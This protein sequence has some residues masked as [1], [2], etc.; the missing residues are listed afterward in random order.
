MA[1]ITYQDKVALNQE[2]SIPDIN[3]VKDTDMNQIK[4]V[5]NTNETKILLAVSSTAPAQCSTGDMYFNTTT[6]LIYTAIAT[7]TWGA[8]GTAP[9]STTIYVV[10]STNSTYT[11]DG[12]TLVAIGGKQPLNEYSTSQD[13][14]YSAYYVNNALIDDYSTT[15]VK[16]NK[17]WVNGKPVY[18][19]VLHFTNVVRGYSGR[20]SHNISNLDEVIEIGGYV[21]ITDGYNPVARVVCDNITGAGFGVLNVTTQYVATLVGSSFPTTNDVYIILEY[22]KTTDTATRTVQEPTRTIEEDNR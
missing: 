21:K 6:N 4:D 13:T 12:T 7:D 8:T 11:Y 3:K 1:Q 19:K 20:L 9:T 10:L 16:T 17:I 18:R 14:P 22:T 2:A 5:V 15:E